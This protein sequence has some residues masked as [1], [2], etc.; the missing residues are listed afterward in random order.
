MVMDETNFGRE[1]LGTMTPDLEGCGILYVA[2]GQKYLDEAEHSARSVRLVSPELLLAIV[3][4]CAPSEEL[5]DVRLRT[6]RPEYSFIDKIGALAR[7][8][9]EKTLFWTPIHLQ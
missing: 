7:T 5:F 9:F 6:T 4:D 3:S 8:P 1:A 2:T